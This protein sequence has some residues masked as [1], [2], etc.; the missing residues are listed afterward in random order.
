PGGH[1]DPVGAAIA[2]RV[3]TGRSQRGRWTAE[4][5]TWLAGRLQLG[6]GAPVDELERAVPRLRPSCAEQLTLWLRDLDEHV[7]GDAGLDDGLQLLAAVR[8]GHCWQP[9]RAA[10]G[11]Y[12]VCRVDCLCAGRGCRCGMPVTAAGVTHIWE[13]L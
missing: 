12:L 1:G 3:S 8:C 10:P 9:V 11:G 5:L 2:A 7:R 13:D 4:T 6:N